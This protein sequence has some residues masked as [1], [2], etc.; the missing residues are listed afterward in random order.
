LGIFAGTVEEINDVSED[1]HNSEWQQLVVAWDANDQA[2]DAEEGAQRVSHWEI[3]PEDHQP[4]AF[5]LGYTLADSEMGRIA[6]ALSELA[7]TEVG[8]PFAEPVDT[9]VLHAVPPST[10]YFSFSLYRAFMA[11]YHE[12]RA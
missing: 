2:Q 11:R 1:F 9:Q 12:R 7:Q 3:M 8:A 4:S 10:H 6:A 5:Q